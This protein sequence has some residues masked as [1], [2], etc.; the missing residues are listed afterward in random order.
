MLDVCI[1]LATYNG[2]KYLEAQLNSL[3]SQ[4]FSNFICYI[5]DDGSND[6]TVDIIN[7]YCCRFPSV[8]KKVNA[9][10]QGGAKNNFMFLLKNIG[11]NFKYI[12]FCDQDDVWMPNK[13]SKLL[14]R[15]RLINCC[16]NQKPCLVYSDMKVTDKNL[17]IISNSFNNYNRLEHGNITPDR[18]IMKG[19]AA[20][21][22]IMINQK[23]AKLASVKDY[24]NIIM[25]DWWVILV[26]SLIGEISFVDIPLV[27]YRQH[28]HNTLGAKKTT[29]LSEMRRKFVDMITFK[30]FEI[31]RQGLYRRI[32][33]IRCL[34]QIVGIYENNK[35]LIDKAIS[36]ESMKKRQ[37]C[38]FILNY[39]LHQTKLGKV[40]T[41]IC[42]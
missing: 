21:C 17:K 41:C 34:K 20:G 16:D 14:E 38:R 13:L 22:S 5:H 40:W 6:R 39:N 11:V 7:E 29:F 35:D 18:A 37:R 42:C 28:E 30:Q 15:M 9:P 33:Q 2:E 23:L 25:H 8:F 10:V 31:T 24:Q 32:R 26:A 3:L 27:L 19:Y 1:L 36:F 4:D 12:V